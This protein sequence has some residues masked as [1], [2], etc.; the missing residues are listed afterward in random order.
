MRWSSRPPPGGPGE[1]DVCLSDRLLLLVRIGL[2]GGHLV[3]LA[4]PEVMI[5]P[6]TAVLPRRGVGGLLR[7]NRYNTREERVDPWRDTP[8]WSGHGRRGGGRAVN[9]LVCGADGA[10]A[11]ACIHL[12]FFLTSL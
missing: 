12:W 5:W 9:R 3:R 4:K 6:V 11:S 7:W 8:G 2:R 10:G 1:Q